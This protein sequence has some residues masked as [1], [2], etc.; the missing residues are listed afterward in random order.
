VTA[1]SVGGRLRPNL[2]AP[3]GPTP[4]CSDQEVTVN[5]LALTPGLLVDAELAYRREQ[6]AGDLA[7]ARRLTRWW[8]A[9]R[10]RRAAAHDDLTLA[11]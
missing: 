5:H 3:G 10:R 7:G 8:A 6:L 2:V 4:G 11:A 1:R 9:A